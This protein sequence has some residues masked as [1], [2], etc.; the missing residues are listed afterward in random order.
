MATVENSTQTTGALQ[1]PVD[2]R[3]DVM[4]EM[5]RKIGS[6]S[7][8]VALDSLS[9]EVPGLENV[10]FSQLDEKSK[11][12]LR[13]FYRIVSGNAATSQFIATGDTSNSISTMLPKIDASGVIKASPGL[14]E[15]FSSNVKKIWEWSG[16]MA[17]S[18]LEMLKNP[19]TWNHLKD[20]VVNFASGLVTNITAAVKSGWDD[21]VSE[22]SDPQKRADFIRRC[23]DGE[24]YVEIAKKGFGLLKNSLTAVKDILLKF[25]DLAGLSDLGEAISAFCQGDFDKAKNSLG[26]AGK[27]FFRLIGFTDLIEGFQD[28]AKALATDDKA[29]FQQ[30]LGHLA[31]GAF[32]LG[33][34]LFIAGKVYAFVQAGRAA[35]TT[36]MYRDVAEQALEVAYNSVGKSAAREVE[37]Q[38][39][40]TMLRQI[41]YDAGTELGTITDK[42]VTGKING[43]VGRDVFAASAQKLTEEESKLVTEN[44]LKQSVREEIVASVRSSGEKIGEESATKA[45]SMAADNYATS[46]LN[47]VKKLLPRDKQVMLRFAQHC[48]ELGLKELSNLDDQQIVDLIKSQLPEMTDANE[49]ARTAKAVMHIA[50]DNWRYS[51]AAKKIAQEEFAKGM[52]SEFMKNSLGEGFR[53]GWKTSLNALEKK[54][55]DANVNVDELRPLLDDIARAGEEGFESGVYKACLKFA[56]ELFK[57]EKKNKHHHNEK[58]N[59]KKKGKKLEEL[60]QDEHSSQ[61]DYY[62]QAKERTIDAAVYKD[63]EQGRDVWTIEK[64]VARAEEQKRLAGVKKGAP[65]ETDPKSTQISR[66]PVGVS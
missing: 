42:L 57:K 48:K 54:L 41:G 9:V 39:S 17:H 2:R 6:S 38:V 33:T 47:A 20:S 40:A 56:E 7:N 22:L 31:I 4:R 23:L 29:L 21:L 50:N 5:F 51:A 34:T 61:S 25:S 32:K 11:T 13:G 46:G 44:L 45:I 8:T 15:S 63:L 1:I 10:K 36:F 52:T 60:S 55:S 65:K 66:D 28:L 62:G 14:L 49:I 53:D 16:E 35:L 58:E 26:K 43:I 3:A 19:Q 37:T 18:G 59:K 12:E 64:E 30:A 27:K 24:M